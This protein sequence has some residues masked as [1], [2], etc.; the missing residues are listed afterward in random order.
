M[1]KLSYKIYITSGAALS[2]AVFGREK[3]PA[4]IFVLAGTSSGVYASGGRI[5]SHAAHRSVDLNF[6]G[7]F[8][9]R[10]PGFRELYF[11]NAILQAGFDALFLDATHGE[12]TLETGGAAFTAD[13][14]TI[15]VFRFLRVFSL[16]GQGQD[17]VFV[18]DLNLIFRLA[19]YV[20]G[21][22]IVIFQIFNIRFWNGN[23]IF[24]NGRNIIK[25]IIND[26]ITKQTRK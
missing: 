11:Q 25:E 26:R 9:F 19:R 16:C 7:R 6:M 18:S 14:L 13:K 22:F 3:V 17:T 15:C 23:I 24:V 10:F 2:A 21:Y 5:I 12:L 8:D 20:T 4:R 1:Y